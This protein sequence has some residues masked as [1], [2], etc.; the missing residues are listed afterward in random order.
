M[1]LFCKSWQV[2][3]S[4]FLPY[5]TIPTDAVLSLDEDTVL[6]TTEVRPWENAVITMMYT[7][8]ICWWCLCLC[9][10]AAQ[11]DFAFTVWQ[12]FPDRIVG[13]PA[14]SHFWDSNKQRW[15]YTSKWT[16]D[17]SM[18]LTG[19]A[20]YHKYCA[21]ILLLCVPLCFPDRLCTRKCIFLFSSVRQQHSILTLGLPSHLDTTITCTPPT[22]Q[23]V[24]RP[25][26]T[27]C[28]TV[29]TSWWISWCPRSLDCHQS[30]SHR[31]NNTRRPWWGRW[32]KRERCRKTGSL[33]NTLWTQI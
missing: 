1:T 30:R 7:T 3:N 31:R 17:Y 13:Y 29:R 26:L 8:N 28:Q 24:W 10:I 20:I 16:N 5:D 25:W 23:S 12:S 33:H 27:S 6:S 9:L 2:I 18:V 19:A 21:H 14:R 11:V 4:R 22:F 15:G 32:G